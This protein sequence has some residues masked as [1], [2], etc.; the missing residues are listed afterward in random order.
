MDK[1]ANKNGFAARRSSNILYHLRETQPRGLG[2]SLRPYVREDPFGKS[3][4][5][6]PCSQLCFLTI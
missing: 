5:Y 6:G 3:G 4:Q 2:F 1:V